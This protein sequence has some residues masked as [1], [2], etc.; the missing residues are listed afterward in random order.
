MEN[1]WARWRGMKWGSARI[2]RAA[3]GA[4]NSDYFVGVVAL[5]VVNALK[6][7]PWATFT[8]AMTIPIALLMGVYLRYLRPGRV[9]EASLIGL[10]LVLFVVWPGSGGGFGAVGERV[11]VEWRGAGVLDYRVRICGVGV[12][13]LVA[14]GSPGLF[15]R[16]H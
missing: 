1:R 8:L 14:A 12:A 7:S 5:V 2:H 6:T 13:G 15:E 16:V 10:A 11:Y 9:L 3:C 4:G